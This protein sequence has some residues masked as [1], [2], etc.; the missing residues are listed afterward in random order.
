MHL[1]AFV[2]NP[3]QENTF[4]I[5]DDDRRCA[6][7]D[8]GCYTAAECETLRRFIDDQGLTLCRVLCT[9]GHF[10][11]VF[12]VPFLFNTYGVAPEVHADDSWWIEN[13]ATQL[14]SFGL[15][16]PS[17]QSAFPA[18]TPF[19]DGDVLAVGTMRLRVLHLPGHSQGSVAL[20]SDDDRLAFVG[21]TVFAGGGVGRTDLHGGDYHQLLGSIRRL[22][23]ELPAGT[24]LYP[25]HGPACT[26]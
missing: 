1:Q 23:N 24:L 10:D 12:G 16:M 5:W 9:H 19:A 15:P 11:H 3:V 2:F 14:R 4:V 13:N 18:V 20:V 22:S 7:V 26:L 21:D 25:G 17:R 6:V 8:P